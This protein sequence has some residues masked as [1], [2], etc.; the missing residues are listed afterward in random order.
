[1]VTKSS[2]KSKNRQYS[3]SEV[4]KITNNFKNIIGKGGFGNVYLG[5]LEDEIQVAV[6]L[7]SP[8]SNQGYKEFRAEAQLLMV[9]HHRNLVTLV[10]YCDDGENKSL[11]YEY[12]ANG[13]CSSI[14]QVFAISIPTSG[15]FNKKS[16]VYSFGIILFELITGRPA[17]IRGPMR[18]N[19]ILD[20]VYPLIERADIQNIVDPR[21]EGEFN[22]TSEWKVVEIA[23]SCA[24][25]VAIQRPDMS[26]VL[27]ELNECLAQVFT[28]GRNQRMTTECRTSSMP[29]NTF[30]L[31]LESEIAPI[32]R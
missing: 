27:A 11:I 18:N 28:R 1:M 22:T 2:I 15:N 10:G 7:L 25:P 20:W 14:C 24:L 12:M 6:K 21:L 26:Q 23:M 29:H 8:S 32:A 16:D 31:E 13:N 9:V 4:V 5:K 17:I 3:Y 30:H 19:H